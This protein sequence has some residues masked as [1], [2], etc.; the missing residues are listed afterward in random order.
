LKK[1][2]CFYTVVFSADQTQFVDE[3]WP[4]K[5]AFILL[6]RVFQEVPRVE[7]FDHG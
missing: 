3:C 2:L 4:V 7:D 1:T 5:S 6:F